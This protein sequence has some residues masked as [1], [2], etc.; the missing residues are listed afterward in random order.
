MSPRVRGCWT[1]SGTPDWEY[2]QPKLRKLFEDFTRDVLV[3]RADRH[4]NMVGFYP[5]SH[6]TLPED[7]LDGC[8]E[9]DGTHVTK[10]STSDNGS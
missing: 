3:D 4:M 1:E 6:E 8:E 10:G 7:P 9:E 2:Y 5:V